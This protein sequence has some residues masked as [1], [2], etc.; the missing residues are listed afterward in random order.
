MRESDCR[1]RLVA[2]FSSRDFEV[3]PEKRHGWDIVAR[4]DDTAW[5]IEV[6]GGDYRNSASYGVDFHTAVGQVASRVTAVSDDV[7]YAIAIPYSEV[8]RPTEFSYRSVLRSYSSSLFWTCMRVWL[9]LVKE[10]SDPEFYPPDQ[11]TPYLGGL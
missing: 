1:A 11:V 10:D 4:S 5:F 3:E 7:R 2:W 8:T 9:V 6:K